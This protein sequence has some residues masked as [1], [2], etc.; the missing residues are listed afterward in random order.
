M[1]WLSW[2]QH[3]IE[4]LIAA[5]LALGLAAAMTVVMYEANVGF[6]AVHQACP[7]PLCVRTSTSFDAQ[8]STLFTLFE[9]AL[10]GLPGLAGI[11]IGAP[12]LAR[13]FEQG[14]ARLVWTQGITRRRW[15]G[16]KLGLILACSALLGGLLGGVATLM[17]P[18]PEG[19]FT[20]RWSAFD[21][22][23]PVVVAY[24]VFGI[25]LGAAAGM[26]IRRVVPAM[27]A[28]LVVF[29]A[30]RL[31]VAQLLRPNFLP[32]VTIDQSKAGLNLGDSWN[33]GI[34]AVDLS[35]HPVSQDYYN[36]VM[37]N[38]GALPGSLADYL[39]AHGIA[40]LYVYQP[41]SRFWLFQSFETALFLALAGLLIAAVIWST[42]RA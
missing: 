1:L 25:A 4:L 26:I 34:R 20:D 19:M 21:F 9:G 37:A 2:R 11:F 6:G 28:T 40:Q 5:G 42:R 7:G 15:L 35:G 27:A 30:V 17:T 14:T 31:A 33:L 10:L 39:R 3:R 8:Y 12:L 41:E 13:E 36:Q 32:P 24:A 38:A 22:Q 23:A 29:T 16:A 18:T